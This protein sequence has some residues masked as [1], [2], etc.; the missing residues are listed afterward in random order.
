MKQGILEFV[1]LMIPHYQHS[2]L[3]ALQLPWLLLLSHKMTI[4]G[5]SIIYQKHLSK[6]IHSLNLRG[7]YSN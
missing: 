3:I 1:T 7:L 6:F 4:A 2:E 5:L